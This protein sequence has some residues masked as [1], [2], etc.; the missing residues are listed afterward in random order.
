MNDTE[1]L[2]TREY[3]IVCQ[4]NNFLFYFITMTEL[5]LEIMRLWADKTLGFGCMVEISDTYYD[6][7]KNKETNIGRRLKII[8]NDIIEWDYIVVWWIIKNKILNIIWHPITRWRLC[9]L[10]Q[11]DKSEDTVVNWVKQKMEKWINLC[12]NFENNL[13]LYNKTILEWNEKTQNIV[14]DFLLSIQ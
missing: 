13:S 4:K 2:L 11:T 12:W 1:T 14:K 9:Y 3:K 7:V 5:Q 8:S 6:A 10:R